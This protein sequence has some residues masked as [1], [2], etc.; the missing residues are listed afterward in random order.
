MKTKLIIVFS[1]FSLNSFTQTILPI[2]TNFYQSVLLDM[3]N[4]YD[5]M[6]IHRHTN[7]TISDHLYL[8]PSNID[9]FNRSNYLI[10]NHRISILD[11][12]LLD[13]L[14]KK[15]KRVCFISFIP[16]ITENGLIEVTVSFLGG[17]Y[18]KH[19]PYRIITECAFYKLVYVYDTDKSEWR[20]L[21]YEN[22]ITLRTNK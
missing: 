20:F 22:C 17:L 8:N 5:T 3:V 2:D 1:I 15:K 4:V 18:K 6:Y 16:E 9:F 14:I 7:L 13:K 11:D 12:K 19:K 21:K 10:N